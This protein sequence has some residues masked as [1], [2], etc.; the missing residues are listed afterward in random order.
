MPI[1]MQICFDNKIIPNV[2]PT[3]FLGMTIDNSLTWKTH[4]ELLVNKFS[5]AYYIMRSVEPHMSHSIL[6]TTYYSL[7]HSV[8]PYGIIF[9]GNSTHRSRIFKIQKRAVRIIMEQTSRDSCRN[10]FKELKIL[11][12]TSQYIISSLFFKIIIKITLS[13]I[14]KIAVYIPEVVIIFFYPKLTWLF[15]K[16]VFIIQGFESLITF[17]NILKMFLR[18]KDVKE[19]YNIFNHT[20]LLHLG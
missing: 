13:Q 6:I 2:T 19:F 8:M 10:L 14:Q 16:S 1:D 11:P 7:L 20:L 15:V 3:K 17:R 12:L 18:I 9:W 4:L 5:A